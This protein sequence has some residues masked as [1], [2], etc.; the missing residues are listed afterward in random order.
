VNVLKNTK[1][2]IMLLQQRDE[3]SG[4][5]SDE[6]DELLV[7]LEEETKAVKETLDF[8]ANLDEGEY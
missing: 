5:P 1:R 3:M 7:L 6:Y 4:L 2:L 8:Y